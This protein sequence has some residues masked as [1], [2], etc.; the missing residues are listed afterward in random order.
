MSHS[1][2]LQR[3]FARS[4]IDLRFEDGIYTVRNDSAQATILLPAALPLE[5]KAVKQLLAFASVKTPGGD[6]AVCAACATP[7]FH[8]G[9]IAPVG[10]VV[11][12]PEDVVIPAAI[13]TDIN[14]GMRLV[15]T[16]HLR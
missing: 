12:T 15:T 9:S 13:G 10:A 11:A 4:H 16:G 14:C 2:R 8:P 5:E 1:L 3:A 7:D 6:A